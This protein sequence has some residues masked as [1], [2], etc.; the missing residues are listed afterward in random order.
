MANFYCD[1]SAVG[2]EYQAYA[3]AMTWGTGATDKPLPQD[4]NGLAG[5]GHSAAVAIAEILVNTQPADANTLVIAGATITAKTTVVAKN[6]FA[7]GAS[8][9]ATVTNIVS[10]IN[11]YGTANNQCD[12]TMPTTVSALALPLSYWCYARVKPGTTDTIQIATRIADSAMNY[13]ATLRTYMLISHAGWGT[14]PTFTQ[15]AGGADGPFGYILS[16]A[17]LFGKTALQ[18]GAWCS[19]SAGVGGPGVADLVDVRTKRDSLDLTVSMSFT[20]TTGGTWQSRNFLYDDGTVWNDGG[21][22]NG[23]LQVTVINASGNSFVVQLAAPI[24]SSVSHVSRQSGGLHFKAQ[25]TTHLG[26]VV[27]LYATSSYSTKFA[28]INCQFSTS[29]MVGIAS[30][31]YITSSSVNPSIDLSNSVFA[32]VGTVQK[33]ITQ[34]SASA[35]LRVRIKL[36]N[37]SVVVTSAS[38]TIAAPIEVRA[39]IG[40]MEWIGGSITDTNGVHTCANPFTLTANA[41]DMQVMCDGVSGVTGPSIGWTSTIQGASKLIWSSTEGAYKGFR[42]ETPGFVVDWKGNGQF[43][44]CGAQNLQGEYLSHRVTWL[45]TPDLFVGETPL[46]LSRFYRSASSI[47]IL[48]LE[49]YTPDATTFYTDQFEVGIGYMDSTDVWRVESVGAPRLMQ[50]ASGRTALAS[51][52]KVWTSNGVP[53][54]SAKKISLTTAYAVKQNTEVLVR[55]SL[56]TSRSSSITLYVSPEVGLA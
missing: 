30:I 48:T 8:V 28:F 4:G 55:L 5:P 23:S 54:H 36:N 2:N 52:S 41:S 21:S 49:L 9:A 38:T 40:N 22:S 20:A 10:L 37:F 43:P 56:V 14:A 29:N 45:T 1:I 16:S 39:P 7:I 35:S 44:H 51:S 26:A 3:N 42:Y 47:V 33:A 53:D 6:Q 12:A 27:A 25:V 15:F 31:V 50:L 17:T 34:S 46:R 32:C 19:A 18:Y 11:T 24:S 13:H